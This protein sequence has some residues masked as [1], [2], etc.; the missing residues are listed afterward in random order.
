MT[1]I[2][3]AEAET[4][5]Y[6]RTL[7]FAVM[8]ARCHP[9]TLAFYEYWNSKRGDS[10]APRRA[11]IDPIDMKNWL[12]GIQL[13]DVDQ[14]AR[15]LVYRLVGEVNIA[16]RG[17]NPT[18]MTVEKGGIGTSIADVLHEYWL[19]VDRRTMVYNWAAVPCGGGYLLT[20]ETIYLPLSD[21]RQTVN[22]V[23]TY[24]VVSK[25]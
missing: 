5:A 2:E 15:R 3:M 25:S 19:V 7:D 24:S 13:V 6:P 1:G 14:A 17:F 10:F 20:Q 12:P 21:D 8:K 11:D 9:Q 23:V 16:A 22:R 18:G 4:K